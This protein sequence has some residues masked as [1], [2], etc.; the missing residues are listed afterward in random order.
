MGIL[1][2][3]VSSHL[4]ASLSDQVREQR[5]GEESMGLIVKGHVSIQSILKKWRLA[6]ARLCTT[7]KKV[8]REHF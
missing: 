3:E 7:H 1:N 4:R 2:R 5:F 6:R 8:D